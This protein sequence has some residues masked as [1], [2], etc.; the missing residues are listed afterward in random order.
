VGMHRTCLIV[1]FV[2]QDVA[3][4]RSIA[5]VLLARYCKL[6]SVVLRRELWKEEDPE[7]ASTYETARSLY[8]SNSQ[9]LGLSNARPAELQEICHQRQGFISEYVEG[10]ARTLGV[11]AQAK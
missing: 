2:I 9:A 7:A 1:H 3:R 10:P 8:T 6:W 4:R 11:S 5:P